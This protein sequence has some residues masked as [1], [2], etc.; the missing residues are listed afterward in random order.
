MNEQLA[1]N[2]KRWQRKPYMMYLFLT[3]Q[4]LVFIGMELYGFLAVKSFGG[5]QMTGVLSLFG[6]MDRYQIAV[7]NQ[8][9]RLVTPIFVHIGLAHIVLNS[10]T[11]YFIGQQLE[12]VFGHT[13]FTVI[14]LLSGILGNAVSFGFGTG[15][16]SAGASTSLFGLFGTYIALG[17]IY[18]TDPVIQNLA[19]SMGMFVGMNLLF[20]LFS[21][22][23]DIYGHIGGLIG[24]ILI[25]AVLLL[26]SR[27]NTRYIDQEINIHGR[28]ISG[29]LYLFVLIVAILLGLKK[30]NLL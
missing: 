3:I 15:A 26:P 7:D 30:M 29:I 5:S 22:T 16:I 6:A 13:R 24:G 25:T 18:R 1:M 17:R 11:L 12:S 20:N 27:R 4:I 23:I 9:W 10:V 19:R 8:W 14:Y 21:P 28:I 2:V